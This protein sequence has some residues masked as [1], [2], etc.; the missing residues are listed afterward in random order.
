MSV[1]LVIEVL[2][3]G[4]SGPGDGVWNMDMGGMAV[5]LGSGAGAHSVAMML[6]S[7]ASTRLVVAALV[8]EWHNSGFLFIERSQ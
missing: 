3:Y 8:L 6:R 4:Q 7:R 2:V 1:A 5:E